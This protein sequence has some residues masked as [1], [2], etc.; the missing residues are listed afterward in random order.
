[1]RRS[2]VKPNEDLSRGVTGRQAFGINGK[3]REVLIPPVG[4]LAMKHSG[5]L[6]SKLWVLSSIRLELRRPG[7]TKRSAT[8]TELRLEVGTDAVGH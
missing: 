2:G 4:E 1:M 5:G 7:V 8:L 3:R 6:I